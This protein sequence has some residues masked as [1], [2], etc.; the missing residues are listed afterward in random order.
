MDIIPDYELKILIISRLDVSDKVSLRLTCTKFNILLKIKSNKRKCYT[1]D[2]CSFDGNIGLIRYISTPPKNATYENKFK[3]AHSMIY[4]AILAYQTDTLK[5]LL[6]YKCP[7][8]TCQSLIIACE[9]DNSQALKLIK[10]DVV[11]L[12]HEFITISIRN[13]S[14]NCL[15]ILIENNVYCP[16]NFADYALQYDSFECL[17][18]LY[19]YGYRCDD[20]IIYNNA[21]KNEFNECI[22]FV[23]SYH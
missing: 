2:K 16:L 4:N 1:L 15:R 17:K 19:K 9:C 21:K 13:D 14:I 10:K 5:F 6:K 7:I 23:D 20:E 12:K 11:Y 3:W 22:N 8:H 18:L